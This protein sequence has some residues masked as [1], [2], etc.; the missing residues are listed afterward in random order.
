MA[1]TS[2]HVKALLPQILVLEFKVIESEEETDE[3]FKAHL[4]EVKI[5]GV[6]S[7]FPEV[8]AVK[9]VVVEDGFEDKITIFIGAEE[10]LMFLAVQL[11]LVHQLFY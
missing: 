10:F 3:R 7:I 2:T 9:G 11:Q 1:R 4:E 6:L 8:L 5:E